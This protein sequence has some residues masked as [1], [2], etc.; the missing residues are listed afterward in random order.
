M[1]ENVI[2]RVFFALFDVG[3]SDFNLGGVTLNSSDY[4]IRITH[5]HND[6]RSFGK[7]LSRVTYKSTES[8]HRLIVLIDI[9][10]ME[11]K[12]VWSNFG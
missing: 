12:L 2:Q 4:L 10:L 3:G 5:R 6:G 8:L 9:K 11:M 1:Y 7:P